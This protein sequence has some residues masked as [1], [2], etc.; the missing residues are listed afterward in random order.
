MSKKST[1]KTITR[2]KNTSMP[3]VMSKPKNGKTATI[4]VRIEPKTKE[5]AEKIFARLGIGMSDA[6]S[7]FL[8]QVIFHRGIPYELRVPNAATRKAIRELRTNKKLKIYHSTTEMFE[9]LLQ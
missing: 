8:K 6:I 3:K 7:M 5:N 2:A 9:D 4:N 1:T